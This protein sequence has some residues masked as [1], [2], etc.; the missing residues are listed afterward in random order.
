MPVPRPVTAAT[1]RPVKTEARAAAGVVLPM[2][3]SPAARASTPEAVACFRHFHP[4]QE[5]LEGLLPG[6][7]RLL[8]HIAGAVS[9]LAVNEIGTSGRNRG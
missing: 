5:G 3:M 7:G 1:G 4:H 2:P 6:E 9:H 8:G